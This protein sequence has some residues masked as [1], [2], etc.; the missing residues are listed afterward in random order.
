M[1]KYLTV[2][3]VVFLFIACTSNTIIKKP[4]NLISKDEMV[5]L[6]TD[7]LIAQGAENVRNLDENRSVN[8]YP[9]VFEKYNID[10]TQFRES[11]YY[12]TT[13]IDDYDEIIRR[14]QT[15]LEKMMK[16]VDDKRAL[17][18][19]LRRERILNGDK[20]PSIE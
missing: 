17:E 13:K 20:I 6:L 8:Y 19:S 2:L 18:D 11:N 4:D 5:D 7:L 1:S 12:Y 16:E 3:V 15:K 14:V 10:T 9:L